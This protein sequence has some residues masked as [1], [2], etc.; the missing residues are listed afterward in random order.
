MTVQQVQ[1]VGRWVSNKSSNKSSTDLK[2]KI[3]LAGDATN[4]ADSNVDTGLAM[5]THEEAAPSA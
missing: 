3:K 2:L 5:E 1:D 4:T